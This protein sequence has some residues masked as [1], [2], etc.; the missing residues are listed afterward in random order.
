[1]DEHEHTTLA[2]ETE[3]RSRP[4]PLPLPVLEHR[5]ALVALAIVRIGDEISRLEAPDTPYNPESLDAA[6]L[7]L[8]RLQRRRKHLAELYD[9]AQAADCWNCGLDLTAECRCGAPA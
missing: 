8:E 1:M 4:A 3:T 9:V 5:I 6:R 2:T 7:R